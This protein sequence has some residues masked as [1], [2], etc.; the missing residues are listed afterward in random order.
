MQNLE[1]FQTM[2]FKFLEALRGVAAFLVF[3]NHIQGNLPWFDNHKNLFV[4]SF[5]AW[6]SE[7][8]IVFFILSGVVIH[9]VS[10][11]S[12]DSPLLFLK[13]RAVRLLPIYYV[14]FLL[15]ECVYYV[16]THKFDST[17]SLICSSL[18]LATLQG[19]FSR[20]LAFNPVIWSLSFELFFYLFFSFSIG[21]HQKIFLRIWFVCSLLAV[22][23]SYFRSGNVIFDY[24]V[25]MFSFSCL[26]LMGYFIYG[27]RDL[28]KVNFPL[29]VFSA[30]MV[31][32]LSRLQISPNYFDPTI[33]LISTFLWL[34]F[35]VL[36]LRSQVADKN[37]K[38][39]NLNHLFYIPFYLAL[40]FVSFKFSKSLGITKLVYNIL[41]LLALFLLI[42]PFELIVKTI[43]V[44][45]ISFFTFIGTISYALYLLHTPFV[46]LFG[47]F[48][49][50]NLII[51]LIGIV[52]CSFSLS[53]FLEFFIQKRIKN[54][55]F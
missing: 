48:F 42:R 22:F 43:L 38:S 29:A 13:K 5:S 50:D 54:L 36:A 53:I 15:V 21:K 16:V 33:Y 39:L 26:W 12:N 1:S 25:L 4:R 8:V 52:I 19:L 23:L 55:F 2:K 20:P 7:S 6:G 49:P 14:A 41:P 37:T 10:V 47:H 9:H 32:C 44:K 17:E 24:L 11:K 3:I 35:F 40:S 51:D 18:F 34:P 27:W 30:S 28:I 46:H 45:C 31:P